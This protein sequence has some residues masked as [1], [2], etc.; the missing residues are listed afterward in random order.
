MLSV[1]DDRKRKA[2]GDKVDSRK[3]L[4]QAIRKAPP[5]SLAVAKKFKTISGP[6]D[7]I[8]CNRPFENDTIPINLLDETFGLFKDRCRKPPSTKAMTLLVELTSVACEW[9]YPEE[10]ALRGLFKKK[11]GLSFIKQVITIVVEETNSTIKC[12]T[13]GNLRCTIMPAAIRGCKNEFGQALHQAILYYSRFLDI[14][15]NNYSDCDS[16]FPCIILMDTGEFEDIDYL[17]P[18]C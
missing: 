5:S 15:L 13:D 10:L 16:R 3:R 7:A 17:L 8:G 18:L 4:R 6:D 12:T 1:G 9:Y 14:A 11:A 2:L